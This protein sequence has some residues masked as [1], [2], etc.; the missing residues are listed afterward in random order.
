MDIK[1]GAN[2]R[3]GADGHV[4]V[5]IYTHQWRQAP[6]SAPTRDY[7]H[8]PHRRETRRN[9]TLTCEG[10]SWRV[11]EAFTSECRDA[12]DNTDYALYRLRSSRW[13]E[14][15]EGQLTMRIIKIINT[16]KYAIVD[17]AYAGNLM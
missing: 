4:C 9:N 12:S 16:D 10:R 2:A 5:R 7:W 11:R 3:S 6:F 8:L 13:N 14:A 17:Q 15:M 1:T